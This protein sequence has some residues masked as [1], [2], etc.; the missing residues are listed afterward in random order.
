MFMIMIMI[1]INAFW[2][3]NKKRYLLLS[4]TVIQ[5]AGTSTTKYNYNQVITH[6]KTIN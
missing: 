1:K 4:Q 6:L 2:T 5:L 3:T